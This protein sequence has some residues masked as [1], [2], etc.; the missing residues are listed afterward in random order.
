MALLLTFAVLASINAYIAY[1]IM[2]KCFTDEEW[3]DIFK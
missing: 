3:K 2:N 1:N